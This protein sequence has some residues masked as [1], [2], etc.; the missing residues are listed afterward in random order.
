MCNN[1]DSLEHKHDTSSMEVITT[2]T[3]L[4]IPNNILNNIQGKSIKW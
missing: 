1:T 4:G 2:Q 3:N